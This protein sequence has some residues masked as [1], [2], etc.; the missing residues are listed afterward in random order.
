MSI[1]PPLSRRSVPC[2]PTSTLPETADQKA[3]D[4]EST[5]ERESDGFEAAPLNIRLR[6]GPEEPPIPRSRFAGRI[7]PGGSLAFCVPTVPQTRNPRKPPVPRSEIPSSNIDSVDPTLL[8]AYNSVMKER[9]V[10]NLLAT[11]GMLRAGGPEA[12]RQCAGLFRRIFRTMRRPTIV[13][14]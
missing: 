6:G 10:I 14:T 2:S 4:E 12:D 8:I 3:I 7:R 1:S 5:C 13:R 9:L 11:L